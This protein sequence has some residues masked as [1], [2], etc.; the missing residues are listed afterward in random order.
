MS[1]A[2]RTD[3]KWA[4]RAVLAG[5]AALAACTGVA[6]APREAEAQVRI[7]EIEARLGGRVG[8]AALDTATGAAIS[9]RAG[10][11]FAMCSTFKWLLAAAALETLPRD[12]IVRYGQS[13]LVENS[14]AASARVRDAAMSVQQLCEAA[15]VVGDNTAA[16]L[17]L[18]NLNGPEG[19]TQFLR[20]RGD[21][22]TRLD[23]IEPLLNENALGDERD[24]TT[25][26]AMMGSMRRF[27]VGN[28]L[29]LDNR[30]RIIQ[31]MI[32][33]HTGLDRL[34]AGLPANWRAG[35]KTGAGENGATNDVLIAWP[36]GR[37]AILIA[38]Y[39]S[40][41]DQERAA[42]KAG[43]VEIARIVAETWA[44]PL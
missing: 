38:S 28:G 17:L 19:F 36:P 35:D 43:H 16:N 40:E 31:W 5:G 39:M 11:R 14:P 23:R 10:E 9:H 27:L 18:A 3:A 20:S 30:E 42:L 1:S 25:P 4:R 44:A 32:E 2:R 37:A 26:A 33:C 15:I 21:A 8:V 24:T 6:L 29:R 12:L 41:S 22:V 13:D 34:R 7:A